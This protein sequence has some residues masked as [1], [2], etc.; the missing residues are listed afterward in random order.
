MPSQIIG[1]RFTEEM[2]SRVV[3]LAGP[4]RGALSDFVRG[5]V[6]DRIEQ[7]DTG[8]PEDSG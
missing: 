4:D 2:R 3:Q 5:A 1:V 6:A 7:E 8:P